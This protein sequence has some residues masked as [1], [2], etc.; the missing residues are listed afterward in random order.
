MR[1]ARALV[2]ALLIGV[3]GLFALP[4]TAAA[5]EPAAAVAVS[6]ASFAVP[7]VAQQQTPDPGPKIDPA[8]TDRANGELARNKVIVGFIAAVLLLLVLWGRHLR[9]KKKK[10]TD[11]QAKGK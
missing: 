5:A 2:L 11:A 6:S 10:Q 3:L 4:I 9:K 8:D 1:K 7:I